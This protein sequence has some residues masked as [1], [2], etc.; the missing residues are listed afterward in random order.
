MNPVLR[1]SKQGRPLTLADLLVPA[2]GLPRSSANLV[3]TAGSESFADRTR[4][5]THMS[6]SNGV[7]WI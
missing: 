6:I 5:A 7:D 3:T 1:R 4:E 2:T